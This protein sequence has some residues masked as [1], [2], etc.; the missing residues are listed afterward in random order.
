MLL[1]DPF[2]PG[3]FQNSPKRENSLEYSLT[4]QVKGQE[5]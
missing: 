1:R 2:L 5:M 4:A 3:H